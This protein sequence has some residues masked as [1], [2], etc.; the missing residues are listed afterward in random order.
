[1]GLL[2]R[3]CFTTHLHSSQGPGPALEGQ[4]QGQG[5][6]QDDLLVRWLAVLLDLNDVLAAHV[7]N[8]ASHVQEA[9]GG[10]LRARVE[11]CI[12]RAGVQ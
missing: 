3:H 7:A 10:D 2:A 5:H 11:R 8:V 12:V 6:I 4:L 9:E 1:M